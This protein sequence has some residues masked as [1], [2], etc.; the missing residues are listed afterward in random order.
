MTINNGHSPDVWC[1][2]SELVSFWHTALDIEYSSLLN[3]HKK[4]KSD[5]LNNADERI[6]LFGWLPGHDTL[7]R[8]VRKQVNEI[9]SYKLVRHPCRSKI[10]SLA[11]LMGLDEYASNRIGDNFDLFEK[12]FSVNAIETLEL[13]HL[14]DI[15]MMGVIKPNAERSYLASR[16]LGIK[17]G[18]GIDTSFQA[19]AVRNH[20]IRRLIDSIGELRRVLQRKGV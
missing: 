5:L 2:K 3:S 10:S 14:L 1:E 11:N 8:D 18:L 17:N 20:C 15:P 9:Q 19:F 7:K 12:Y 13:E 16:V 6:I 4:I